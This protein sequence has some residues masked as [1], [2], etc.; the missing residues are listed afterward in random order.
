MKTI[1]I[2]II[3]CGVI[4]PAH[5]ESYLL[6]PDVK[7][8]WACDLLPERA[9]K[10]AQRYGIPKT[11]TV[12]TDVFSDPEVDGVSI[13]TPHDAHAPLC[14]QALASGKDVLCEKPL[15]SSPEGLSSM[16]KAAEQYPDGIFAAIFQH[17]FTFL[18]QTLKELIENGKFGKPLTAAMRH[19]CLRTPEYYRKD[20]W[21]GTWAH[22]GGGTLIN[23]S[24]HFLDL[25]QWVMG[26]VQD[27]QG[28][29]ANIGHR[30]V[31]ETEDTLVGTLR[32]R[33]G[34]L[35]TIETTNASNLSWETSIDIHGTEGSVEIRDDEIRQAVFTDPDARRLLEKAI[36]KDKANASK[37]VGKAYYGLGH[38]ANIADFVSSVRNRTRPYVDVRDAA[39]TTAL[40]HKL[41]AASRRARGDSG[42]TPL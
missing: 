19:H 33:N 3:G 8:D 27:C 41:Y 11:T 25:L 12:A 10:I 29:F 36:E 22:E 24:I 7:I 35:G 31:I 34:A 5:I 1:H 28:F 42:C 21:R 4:A 40:V 38:P 39:V 6:L 20:A 16:L 26:G 15:S 2:G 37:M 32:F 17:R 30:D 13:C 9:G 23:Q 18:Y 14:V